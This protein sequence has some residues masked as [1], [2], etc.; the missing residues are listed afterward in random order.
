ML[1]DGH[2]GGGTAISVLVGA[3]ILDH[4]VT[5]IAPGSGSFATVRRRSVCRLTCAMD[6]R[7]L[8]RTR[9]RRLGVKGLQVHILS[10][11]QW[12]IAGQGAVSGH[13]RSG[14]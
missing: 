2:D 12:K 7:E 1:S 5:T 9:G 6:S 3:A 10:A 11:R 14:P 13:I 4:H 8:V